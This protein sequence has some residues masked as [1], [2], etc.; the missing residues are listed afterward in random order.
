MVDQNPQRLHDNW[1]EEWN[2]INDLKRSGI[3]QTYGCWS[4][5]RLMTRNNTEKYKFR[6]FH[7]KSSV[8]LLLLYGKIQEQN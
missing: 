2:L 7:S 5:E 6:F 8:S 3:S 4:L 1:F